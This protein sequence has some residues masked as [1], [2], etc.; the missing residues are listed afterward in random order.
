MAQQSDTVR[1]DGHDVRFTNAEKV[2]Y[3]QTGATKGEVL[4]YYLRIAPLL[5]P[6]AA[7]RPATRKRWVAG[8]GTAEHPGKVFFR[9]DLE[10]GAPDWLPTAQMVH[11]NGT[12]TYPMVNGAAVLAWTSQLGALELHTPQWRFA[13]DGTQANPDRLVIDL[14]P[15]PGVD[16]RGCAEVALLVRRVFSSQSLATYPV[17]SGSKGI[18][19]YVPLDGSL[20][21][22]DATALAKDVASGLQ[23]DYPERV[24]TVQK[25]SERGGRVL[26][27]W[28]QNSRAKTTVCPYSLRGRLIPNVAAPRT[29]EEIEDEDLR[30]LSYLEVLDRVEE[31]F[32]PLSDL[33][34]YEDHA[35][36]V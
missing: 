20:S 9:K 32:D 6:Q 13:S 5:V 4:D 10:P 17:T 12:N 34:W 16:L 8:V 19:V 28:S 30:Q 3:P 14:D 24:V 11:Q 29:W 27:D 26:I 18:H 36:R 35:P 7:W 31:G 25:R 2:F 22:D 1:V 15:G 33:G 23:V 21:S